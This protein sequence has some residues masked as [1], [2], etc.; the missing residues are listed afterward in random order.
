MIV[1]NLLVIF[2]FIVIGRLYHY[3]CHHL[4][5]ITI[6]KLSSLITYVLLPAIIINAMASLDISAEQMK[7]P[8]SNILWVLIMAA[9]S[10]VGCY[11]LNYSKARAGSLVTAF[12]SLEG[13]SIGLVLMLILYAHHQYLAEFFLFDITHAVMLFT[14][15]YFIAYCLLLWQY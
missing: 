2:I 12:C 5:E 11:L 9:I 13:G 14:V 8:L 15:T 3:K 10:M 1:F 6:N 7:L 4:G